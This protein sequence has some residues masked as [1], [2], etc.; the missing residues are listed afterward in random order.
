MAQGS[1]VKGEDTRKEAVK[2]F[3]FAHSF[4]EIDSQMTLERL[5]RS[6]L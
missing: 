3:D 2:S 1:L 4:R 6:R 5:F